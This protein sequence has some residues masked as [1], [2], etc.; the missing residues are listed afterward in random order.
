MAQAM[1]EDLFKHLKQHLHYLM[2][3]LLILLTSRMDHRKGNNKILIYTF[4]KSN[5]LYSA[6]N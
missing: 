4:R 5:I 3:K 2:R 1:P 6:N